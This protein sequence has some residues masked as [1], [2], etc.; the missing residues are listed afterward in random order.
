M[1]KK[2]YPGELS[3]MEWSLIEPIVERARPFNGGKKNGGRN[4]KYG[5]RRMLDAIFYIFR[6]GS[7][8]RLSPL[9]FPPWPN[10]LFSVYEVE[11]K[12]GALKIERFLELI[13]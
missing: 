10:S 2:C 6:L 8:K 11:K 12:T 3:D 13:R 5:K 4:S 9:D 1:E 7:S